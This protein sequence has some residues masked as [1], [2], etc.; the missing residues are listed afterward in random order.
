MLFNAIPPPMY[1][2]TLK[3]Q[4]RDRVLA[5]LYRKGEITWEQGEVCGPITVRKAVPAA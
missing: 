4:G 3:I 1:G 5:Q 2:P